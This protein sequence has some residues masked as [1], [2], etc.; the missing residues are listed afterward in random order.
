MIDM[1][2]VLKWIFSVALALFLLLSF[3]K[4]VIKPVEISQDE[5]RYANQIP[6]FSWSAFWTG[7]Y[8]TAMDRGLGDQI[9]F[10]AHFKKFYNDCFAAADRAFLQLRRSITDRYVNYQNMALYNGRL[11]HRPVSLQDYCTHLDQSAAI[12]NEQIRKLPETDFYFFYVNDDSDINFETGE[13]SGIYPY[14]SEQLLIPADHSDSLE[15]DSFDTFQ[16][17]FYCSDHHWNHKGAYLAYCQLLSLLQIEDDPLLPTEEV[18]VPG[19]FYGSKAIGTGTAF[20]FYDNL[21]AYRFAFPP[22]KIDSDGMPISDYGELE[23]SLSQPKATVSYASIFGGDPGCMVIST[24]NAE[25][26]NLL[27]IGDSFD[28]ALLKLIASHFNETHSIDLRY[29]PHFTGEWFDLEEYVKEHDISKVLL[30]GGREFCGILLGL[31]N[32]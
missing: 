31:E 12:V 30:I 22:M 9:A 21:S 11:V 17:L 13:L 14:Y 28:N 1:G 32:S 2:R 20:Y 6:T 10:S 26:D 18:D 3:T 8:Q 27:V 15:L 5:Q 23:E 29:Y 16:E 19:V 25:K 4:A 24:G 7:E